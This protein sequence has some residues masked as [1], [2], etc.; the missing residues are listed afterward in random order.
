MSK[1]RALTR[2][3]RH[4]GY[5]CKAR[6]LD[7]CE[8]IRV[9]RASGDCAASD[10]RLR[11]DGDVMMERR[12]IVELW[13]RRPGARA[14]HAGARGG[15][16]LSPPGRAAAI[17]RRRATPAPSAAA[18]WK[19]TS[20]AARAW[21]A[22]DRRRHRALRHHLRRHRGHSLTDSAAAAR[23]T[24]CLSRFAT[25]EGDALLQALAGVARG[26]EA[27]RV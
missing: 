11:E 21:I 26:R 9:L 20:S 7:S 22:R 8:F 3:C 17:R 1:G 5:A 14:R 6:A 16:V 25:P 2:L 19:P 10:H 18:A 13:Q 4:L 15:L 27:T 23:S 24:S 12:Q